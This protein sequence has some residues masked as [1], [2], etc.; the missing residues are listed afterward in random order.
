MAPPDA[1]HIYD[2]HVYALD[3]TLDLKNGFYMNEMYWKMKG[4]IL[5]EAVISGE[6]AN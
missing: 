2:I 5:A 3:T 6:Y 4:H 1:P